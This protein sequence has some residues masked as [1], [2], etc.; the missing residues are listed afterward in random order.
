MVGL[1]LQ[2]VRPGISMSSFD[3][4]NIDVQDFLDCLDIEFTIDGDHVRF[5]CPFH[6]GDNP[7]SVRMNIESSAFFCHACKAR[8]NGIQFTAQILSCSPL[9]AIRLLKERYQPGYLNPDAVSMV[10]EVKKI[11]DA[12]DDGPKPQPI[13]PDEIVAHFE[14]N[15][16]LAETARRFGE[17]FPAFDY[18]LDRGFLSETLDKWEFGFDE[19]SGRITLAIRDEIGN[20]IGFKARAWDGREPKYLILGDKPKKPSRYGWPCYFPSRVVF[21][22]HRI[23]PESD[24]IVCEGEFNVI[25]IDQKTGLPAVAINGSHFSEHHALVIRRVARSVTLFL[26][27]DRAGNDCVFGWTD[28]QEKFHPGIMQMLS[29]FLPIRIVPPHEGDPAEMTAEEIRRLLADSESALS[30]SIRQAV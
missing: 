12:T 1:L 14:V 8:G 22:A 27:T 20:L 7:R 17:G 29:P 2:E 9:E 30:L 18:M 10:E 23:P 16:P 15:W 3:P 11:F 13:L 28:E 26:D 19:I 21:G 24:L 4:E 25:A 5:A 6:H